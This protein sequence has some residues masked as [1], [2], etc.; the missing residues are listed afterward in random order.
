MAQ[1][2]LNCLVKAE[3]SSFQWSRGND[4]RIRW[5]EG[6]DGRDKLPENGVRG[7]RDKTQMSDM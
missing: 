6:L 3:A 2:R 1:S 7:D 5:K 4:S